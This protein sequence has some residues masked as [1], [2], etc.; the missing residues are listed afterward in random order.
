M[1]NVFKCVSPLKSRKKWILPGG[2]WEVARSGGVPNLDVSSPLSESLLPLELALKVGAAN[3][4][5]VR[6][7]VVI[8]Q[9]HLSH[10]RADSVCIEQHAAQM[11]ETQSVE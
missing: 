2:R 10:P 1:E 4:L 9:R 6:N 11:G 5:G 3:T 7:Q 8:L